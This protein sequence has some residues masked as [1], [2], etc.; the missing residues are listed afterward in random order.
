METSQI[1]GRASLSKRAEFHLTFRWEFSGP[2]SRTGSS[3]NA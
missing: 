1:L 2:S 3:T